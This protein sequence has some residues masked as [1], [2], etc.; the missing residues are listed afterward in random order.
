VVNVLLNTIG[1]VAGVAGLWFLYEFVDGVLVVLSF[2]RLR[3]SNGL[4]EPAVLSV[5]LIGLFGLFVF[6]ML[7]G[8]CLSVA[9]WILEPVRRWREW[10]A[11]P[12]G[13]Q[14]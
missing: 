13:A 5:A 11:R 8:I 9:Y 7:A 4:G 1:I 2:M 14:A 12:T 10:R 3:Q 6:G